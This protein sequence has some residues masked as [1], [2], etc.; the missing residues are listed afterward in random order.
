MHSLEITI[1]HPRDGHWPVV[2]EHRHPGDLTRR[3]EGRL[4]LDVD[5]K[6]QLISLGQNCRG[7]GSLLGKALFQESIR[8]RFMDARAAAGDDSLRVL[9][10]VVEPRTSNPCI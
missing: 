4:V 9:L 1:Q 6:K 8:N 5:S 7:Y 2:A 3:S 10:V